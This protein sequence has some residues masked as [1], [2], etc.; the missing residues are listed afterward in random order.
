MR[1]GRMEKE[2]TALKNNAPFQNISDA[3]SVANAG[4]RFDRS[5]EQ[6]F[7]AS[8]SGLWGLNYGSI[9]TEWEDLR[10]NHW[11]G[12]ELQFLKTMVKSLVFLSCTQV[13]SNRT[14]TKVSPYFLH[15]MKVVIV[16]K[17]TLNL[18]YIHMVLTQGFYW[19]L[20][21]F[22]VSIPSTVLAVECTNSDTLLRSTFSNLR[23]IWAP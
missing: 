23:Q 22:F 20:K 13:C 14:Q 7:W 3:P 11:A 8:M 5:R 17:V 1:C 18:S 4:D 21:Y 15:W 16:V 9:T 12:L 2:R 6:H 19:V 10:S